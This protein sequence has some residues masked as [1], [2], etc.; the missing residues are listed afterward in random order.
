MIAK[1]GLGVLGSPLRKT[2][3]AILDFGLKNYPNCDRITGSIC[4][5]NKAVVR[6]QA[7]ISKISR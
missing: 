6:S 1:F 2:N 5:R 4:I 3:L 7:T